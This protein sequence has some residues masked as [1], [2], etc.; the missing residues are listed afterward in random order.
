MHYATKY[1]KTK[2]TEITDIEIDYNDI[3][4]KS[5]KT[6]YT[7]PRFSNEWEANISS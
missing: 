4:I 2:E 6:T 3:H 5:V 7:A 1:K